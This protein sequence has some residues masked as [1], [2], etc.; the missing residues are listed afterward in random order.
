M[1]DGDPPTKEGG[2]RK[3]TENWK[4]GQAMLV[5]KTLL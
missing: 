5:K 3:G 2:E 1:I 4:G